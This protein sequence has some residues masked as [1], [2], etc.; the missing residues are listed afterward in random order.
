MK[1]LSDQTCLLKRNLSFDELLTSSQLL[2]AVICSYL[3]TL[4]DFSMSISF[5]GHFC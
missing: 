1:K 2:F 5:I 4:L 3:L